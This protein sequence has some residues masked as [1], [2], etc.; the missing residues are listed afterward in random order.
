VDFVGHSLISRDDLFSYR[1]SF[2]KLVILAF[3][4]TPDA[5]QLFYVIPQEH[6]VAF[7]LIRFIRYI[8][9]ISATFGY[10]VRYGGEVWSSKLV[11]LG[12]AAV[13][14]GCILK[15]ISYFNISLKIVRTFGNCFLGIGLLIFAI[16]SYKYIYQQYITYTRQREIKSNDYCCNVYLIS[17]WITC[18]G[19]TFL[20]FFNDFPNWYQIK[21]E[22]VVVETMLFTVYYVLITV[23]Q[24]KAALVD[25]IAS[26][27]CR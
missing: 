21:V 20:L 12:V 14:I 9:W 18:F 1:D 25:A 5:A 6:Y 13:D 4:L 19:L 17:F 24:G 7:V 16:I 22:I 26:K 10:L 3:L 23:F 2:S 11:V 15:F 8:F 27:V